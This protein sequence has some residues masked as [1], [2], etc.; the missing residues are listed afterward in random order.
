M[1]PARPAVL[2][3]PNFM[4]AE[5]FPRLAPR[6][7]E[8]G[9]ETRLEDD[10]YD[11][12]DIVAILAPPVCP[13]DG[14]AMAQFPNL[15]IISTPSVGQDHI[16]LAAARARGVS[17]TTAKGYNSQEVAE[18]TLAAVLM[19]AKDI[20]RSSAD[21]RGGVW[22]AQ[23]TSP[24]LISECTVGLVGFGEVARRVAVLLTGLGMPV[25]VWNRSDISRY[26]ESRGVEAVASLEELAARADV[27]SLH[28][29]L[30]AGTRH[31]VDADLLARM[32][33]GA[34]LVNTGRGGLVDTAAL[35]AAVEKGKLRG[36][37]LD[38]L[39][40]EP[41]RWSDE[42]GEPALDCDGVLV[43]PHIAW[44]SAG[45]RHRGFDTAAA[46]IIEV[47]STD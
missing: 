18:Y 6:F 31:L 15:K 22:E 47:C 25:L 20:V 23:R 39:D 33:P 44:L 26:P 3:L 42:Q 11:P 43:T 5:E 36:A 19:L 2:L 14:V 7:S 28:V 32:K 21:V 1:I 30:V 46:H 16:D 34:G 38:V 12:A 35:R 17:V 9:L 29:P 10:D 8:H 13:V 4:T 41:P 37:V 40:Q 24:L 27:V 45:S